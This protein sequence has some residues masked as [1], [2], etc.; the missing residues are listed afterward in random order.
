[1]KTNNEN[2]NPINIVYKESYEDL[3]MDIHFHNAYEI[4]YIVEGTVKFEVNNKNYFANNNSMIF[5][6]NL[7]SHELKVLT[8]PYK[9]FF[10][11]IDSGSVNSLI[12]DPILASIFKH[13]PEHFN[14]VISLNNKIQTEI[15]RLIN[16]MYEEITLKEDYYNIALGSILQSILV[17]LY[18]NYKKSFPITSLNSAMNTVFEIQK[19]IEEHYLD[20][21]TLKKVAKLFYMDMY[22]LS[23][24]FKKYQAIHLKNTLSFKD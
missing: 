23:R 9:R 19:Y 17:K 21:I 12:A 7:E 15:F 16:N 3:K 24:L 2:Y 14:H 10:I 20:D 1:M 5:V 13:R 22:Y 8:Y 11:L 4:I 6:S 18:R